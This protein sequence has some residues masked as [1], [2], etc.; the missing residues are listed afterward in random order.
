[1]EEITVIS[2]L[3][4]QLPRG[5]R[6]SNYPFEITENKSILDLLW[7]GVFRWK[8]RPERITCDSA[9]GTVDNILAVE[10]VSIRGY[11]PLKQR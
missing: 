1:M 11:V 10:K 9:Y 6:P 4:R 3:D 7:R 5:L 2:G 8:V